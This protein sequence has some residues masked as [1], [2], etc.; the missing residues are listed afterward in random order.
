[1]IRP[2][3]HVGE[4]GEGAKALGGQEPGADQD[5]FVRECQQRPTVFVAHHGPEDRVGPGGAV[6]G[7][8]TYQQRG[9]AA[10]TLKGGEGIAAKFVPLPGTGHQHPFLAL[11]RQ[12]ADVEVGLSYRAKIGH[13]GQLGVT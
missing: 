5:V 11:L 10:D 6:D 13:F 12:E 8:N 3:N 9:R 4:A 2:G 1:M 7:A